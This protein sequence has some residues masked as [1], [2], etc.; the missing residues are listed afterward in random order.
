MT[1][2][3]KNKEHLDAFIA[4]NGDYHPESAYISQDRISGECFAICGC[5]HASEAFECSNNKYQLVIS[6][7]E[8]YQELINTQINSEYPELEAFY[9]K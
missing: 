2:V 4:K 6:D 3:I 7:D 1:T 8:Y 9:L 5:T